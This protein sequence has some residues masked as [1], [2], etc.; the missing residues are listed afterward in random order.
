MATYP[1]DPNDDVIN[2]CV[3]VARIEELLK[4]RDARLWQVIC[5]HPDTWPTDEFF[6]SWAEARNFIISEVG[7]ED[8]PESRAAAT[9]LAYCDE[10]TELHEWRVGDYAWFL[11]NVSDRLEKLTAA[12]QEELD[13]LL[14]LQEVASA[15]PDWNCGE[16][17]IHDSYF[18]RYAKELAEDVR[19]L[20]R[21]LCW[22]FTCIDWNKATRELQNDYVDVEYMGQTFWIRA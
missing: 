13:G 15:S 18:P 1:I 20:P 22:P 3:V 19:R 12:E 5:V 21:E 10:D 7:A 2:S 6:G 4:I 17:L 14:A 9:K 11:W 8:T 16:V